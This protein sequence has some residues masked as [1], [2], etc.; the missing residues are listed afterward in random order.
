VEAQLEQLAGA[1]VEVAPVD[2]I[3]W[4]DASPL[5]ADVLQAVRAAVDATHPGVPVTPTM[6]VGTSDSLFFRA[7]GIPTYGTGEIFIKGSDDF[8]HG[9]DERVPVASFYDGLVHWR[10]LLLRLAGT[11]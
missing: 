2:D 8:A 11:P 1:G 10:T 5:R 9:L 6:G 4:S 3:Y 7:A